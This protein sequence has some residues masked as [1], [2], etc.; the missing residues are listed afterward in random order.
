MK[1]IVLIGGNTMGHVI[2]G[3][4]VIKALRNKYPMNKYIYVTSQKQ[5]DMKII[6]EQKIDELLF[7]EVNNLKRLNELK[8]FF[9]IKKSF[10][11][12][13]QKKKV[14]L[15]ISFGSYLGTIAVLAAKSLQIKTVIH[16]QN[17]IMGFGNKLVYNK[18]DYVFVNYQ[19]KKKYHKQIVV[20]N[21]ILLD[22]EKSLKLEKKDKLVITSGSGGGKIFNQ[23]MVKFLNEVQLNFDI[24]FITGTK[25]YEEINKLIIKK[26]HL[27][28]VPYLDN[29]SK[30]LIDAKYVITRGGATTLAEIFKLKIVPIIVP[31]PYV[32]NNHQYLN[33]L[34]HQK[35]SIIINEKDLN[36]EKLKEAFETL[37]NILRR[38]YSINASIKFLKELE[39]VIRLY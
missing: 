34:N 19:L 36:N 7:I 20:G 14:D 24:T 38:D 37:P 3:L 1:N 2:P 9:K 8:S 25:Y 29:L 17:Q 31:S 22:W 15:V 11:Q 6:K 16:E 18:A 35:E 27:T 4:S 5:Q 12:L 26:D 32:K 10:I 33:A 39:N 28:V 30:Y 13:F 23:K 21:P